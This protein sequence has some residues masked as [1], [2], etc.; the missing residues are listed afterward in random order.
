MKIDTTEVQ[1][2]LDW[3]ECKYPKNDWQERMKKEDVLRSIDN[4]LRA[5]KEGQ[6][7]DH[8]S[9][10]LSAAHLAAKCLMLIHFES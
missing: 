2:V 1:K 10:L 5:V 8:E 3:A 9:G 6:K 7:Y 4:H